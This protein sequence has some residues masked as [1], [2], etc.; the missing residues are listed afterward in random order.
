VDTQQ[1]AGSLLQ[2][3]RPSRLVEGL[4]AHGCGRHPVR[5]K[6]G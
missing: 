4:G 3:H 5:H 6:R 2:E 1:L